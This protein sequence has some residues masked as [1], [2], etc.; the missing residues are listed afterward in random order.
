MQLV[1]Q[2][3]YL[4]SNT[5]DYM[6]GDG[7]LE[8][9]LISN[10]FI[11]LNLDGSLFEKFTFNTNDY[12]TQNGINHIIGRKFIP[13]EDFLSLIFDSNFYNENDKFIMIYVNEN[14]KKIE[15]SKYD[16]SFS[17]WIDYIKLSYIKLK[18]NNL[19]EVKSNFGYELSEESIKNIYIVKEVIEDE[20]ILV[21]TSTGCYRRFNDVEG[22]VKWKKA[23]KL[24]IDICVID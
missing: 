11:I 21:S 4:S 16:V 23:D 14:L 6:R 9:Q 18:K 12:L 13:E 19:L 1:Y 24:L 5:E 3:E 10:E 17:I 8:I 2:D 20:L 7:V 15:K 22:K